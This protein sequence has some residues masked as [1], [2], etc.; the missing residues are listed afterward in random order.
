MLKT[1][2]KQTNV[3]VLTNLPDAAL[4]QRG[5]DLVDLKADICR[6]AY[7]IY[8]TGFARVLAGELAVYEAQIQQVLDE[9][10]RREESRR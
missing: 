2:V 5:M 1:W 10:Q 4:L 9:M 7:R 3:Q 6:V 8:G